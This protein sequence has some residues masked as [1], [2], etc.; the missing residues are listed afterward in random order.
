MML[1]SQKKYITFGNVPGSK[2]TSGINPLVARSWEPPVVLSIKTSLHL[3]SLTKVHVRACTHAC[4]CMHAHAHPCTHTCAHSAVSLHM[5]QGFCWGAGP[6]EG[7]EPMGATWVLCGQPQLHT[8][9]TGIPTGGLST[10]VDVESPVARA[11]C[12]KAG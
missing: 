4:T 2:T 9:V 3:P 5:V 8:H 10:G 12:C 7:L 6:T 1:H 11:R